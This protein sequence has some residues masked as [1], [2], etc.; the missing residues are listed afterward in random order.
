[1]MSDGKVEEK[2]FRF[3][4][5][6]VELVLSL[7]QNDVRFVMGTQLMR[8]GTAIGANIEEAQ[9]GI[10]KRDFTHSMNVAK[11]EAREA[12]YWRKLLSEF[13][14]VDRQRLQKLILDCEELKRILTAIVKT[15]QE[16]SGNL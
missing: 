11:K 8:S 12:L 2:A 16:R 6:I 3:A 4:K 1:M 15:S 9:G 5:N 13:D 7:A 10:S 14:F